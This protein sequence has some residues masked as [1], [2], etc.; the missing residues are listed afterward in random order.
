M[1]DDYIDPSLHMYECPDTLPGG[2]CE[3]CETWDGRTFEDI[4]S[5][6]S[7]HVPA[8]P[9]PPV[10]STPDPPRDGPAGHADHCE[11]LSYEDGICTCHG[12]DDYD[13]EP[14][15]MADLEDGVSSGW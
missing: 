6:L 5:D 3:I 10:P 9:A 14:P 15:D 8:P 4:R 7:G 2:G 13:R 11:R 12:L 1:T